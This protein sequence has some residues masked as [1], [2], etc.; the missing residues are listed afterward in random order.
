M[1]GDR[2]QDKQLANQ[3]KRLDALEEA[4]AKSGTSTA[5]EDI[6]IKSKLTDSDI[7][8]EA[9]K[10][11]EDKLAILMKQQEQLLR[12]MALLK[13]QATAST[14]ELQPTAYPS[15]EGGGQRLRACRSCHLSCCSLSSLHL[16]CFLSGSLRRL[17]DVGPR[18]VFCICSGGGCWICCWL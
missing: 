9:G 15:S 11:T 1:L 4:Q 8:S 16:L 5:K 17:V 3:S 12:D 14:P 6:A 10:P 2:L 7:T 13:V 18:I